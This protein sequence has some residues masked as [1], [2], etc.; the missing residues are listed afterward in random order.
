MNKL[1]SDIRRLLRA[2]LSNKE[3]FYYAS[4]IHLWV[5]EIHPFNDGNGRSARL[6]EKWF[7]VYKLANAWSINSERYYCD[8]IA[9]YYKNIALGVNY[10]FLHWNR[11]LSFLLMLP[12][13]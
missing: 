1:F 6:L 11:C 5:A 13:S 8:N 12:V 7:L 4:M 9:D 10:Y 2:K 3:I